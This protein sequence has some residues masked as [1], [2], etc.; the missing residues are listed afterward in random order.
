MVCPL[1]VPQLPLPMSLMSRPQCR[2]KF[3]LNPT[4]LVWIVSTENSCPFTPKSLNS[5][6]ICPPEEIIYFRTNMG[7]FEKALE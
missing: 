7:L 1:R 3:R 6:V 2:K 5:K 4:V